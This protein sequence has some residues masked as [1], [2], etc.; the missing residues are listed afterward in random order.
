MKL[1]RLKIGNRFRSLPADF[2]LTFADPAQAIENEP[3]C[4]VGLNGSGKSNVLE[5]IAEIFEYL[6]LF[7]LDYVQQYS[8]IASIDQFVIEYLLPVEYG[9]RYPATHR[10][11]N[12]EF[13]HVKIKKL[14]QQNPTFYF[15]Q[16]GQTQTIDNP[17]ENILPTRVIGYSS[18]QNEVLSIPFRKIN[19]KYYHSIRESQVSVGYRGFIKPPRLSYLQ[20]ND[21]VIILLAN[22][23]R[24]QDNVAIFSSRLEIENLS[25]FELVIDTSFRRGN[26]VKISPDLER[27]IEFLK[28]VAAENIY[29]TANSYRLKFIV[30]QD[31]RNHF[32]DQ[33][34]DAASLYS[35]LSQLN[36]LNLN[37]IPKWRMERLLLSSDEKYI[38]YRPNEFEPSFRVF[39]IENVRIKVNGIEAPIDYKGLSDGEHQ[40]LFLVGSLLIFKNETALFLFDEPETHFN[41]K[42]KYEYL[43]T[44]KEVASKYRNQILLTTHDPV[45]VSGLS[46]Q[47]VLIFHRPPAVNRVSRPDKDLKGQGVDAILTSEVFGLNSTL[48]QETLNEILDRRK[49]LVKKE[50]GQLTAAE[51]IELSRLSEKLCNIDFFKPFEDP[52]YKEFVMALDNIDDYK[53]ANLTE[54]EK[55]ERTRIAQEIMER[56]NQREA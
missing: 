37:A 35:V 16:N 7:F 12:I 41:P 42:W 31:L 34:P 17:S 27:F 22:Y 54:E 3:I 38:S 6:D 10:I 25:A 4:F 8:E 18:G 45:L 28:R 5:A 53:R 48:D 32:R 47:N 50:R 52:L 55:N 46:K 15:V 51:N 24:N 44:F 2:E 14:A 49:L 1:I 39:S 11:E 26:A 36:L 33:S 29:I 23:L 21:H 56:I 30:N 9:S 43:D 19:Y 20:Y 40:F 13:T